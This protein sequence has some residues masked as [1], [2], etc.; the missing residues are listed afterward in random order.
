MARFVPE[1]KRIAGRLCVLW[2]GDL[3]GAELAA[4]LGVDTVTISRAAVW[5]RLPR[6]PNKH[7]QTRKAHRKAVELRRAGR[8]VADIAARCGCSKSTVYRLCAEAGLC[9]TRKKTR[10]KS[11]QPKRRCGRAT[12]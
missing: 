11:A 9:R 8:S 10:R 5:L 6:K 4:K 3:S 7:V 2:D 12:T 1:Y